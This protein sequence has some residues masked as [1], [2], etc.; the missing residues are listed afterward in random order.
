MDS[1]LIALLHILVRLAAM[2]GIGHLLWVGIATLLGYKFRTVSR[3]ESTSQHQHSHFQSVEES[4]NDLAVAGLI[5]KPTLFRVLE[6]L[7]MHRARSLTPVEFMAAPT[8][9]KAAPPPLPAI[10]V[11]AIGAGVETSAISD[12]LEL[13]PLPEPTI[14]LP[15]SAPWLDAAVAQAIRPEPDVHKPMPVIQRRTFSGVLASFMEESNIR[16]GELLGGLLIVGC[17]IALVI[18]FWADIASRPAFKFS[19]FT[20]V[21]AAIFGIGLYSEHRWKLPTTSRGVLLIATLLVPLNF[22]AFSAFSLHAAGLIDFFAQ[23]VA[24]LLFTWL[25]FKG[26]KVIAP[27]WPGVLIAGISDLSAFLL[28]AHAIAPR[29]LQPGLLLLCGA[30]PVCVYTLCNGAMVIAGRGWKTLHAAAADAMLLI[31]GVLSFAVV[32]A[33][34]SLIWATGHVQWALT[35]SSPL[36][37]LAGIS[38]MLIGLYV[39]RCAHASNL[40]RHRMTGAF[41]AIIGLFSIIGAMS[42]GWPIPALTLPIAFYGFAICTALA[43][44]LKIPKGHLPALACLTFAWLVGFHHLSAHVPWTSYELNALAGLFVPRAGVALA[45]LVGIIA[46]GSIALDRLGRAADSK[47]YLGFCLPVAGLSLLLLNQ[48]GFGLAG[49]PFVATWVYGGYALL[50]FGFAWRNRSQAAS[51]IGWL[52]ALAAFVQGFMSHSG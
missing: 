31:L 17:S 22:V 43:L 34:G 38:P 50:G 2:V 46:T 36:M 39:L 26:A 3:F 11:E 37:A 27:Q 40:G 13:A 16:W 44:A 29:H 9:Q 30:I 20:A 47:T 4:L 25:S 5:D 19:L 42:I 12:S 14:G 48:Q 35:W 49:D 21:T 15:P 10:P 33:L 18:S 24:L 32:L 23:G 6:A 52:M 1:S 41:A 28:L 7:N 45:I 8:A 51:W